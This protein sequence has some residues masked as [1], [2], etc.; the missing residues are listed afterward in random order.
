M[1]RSIPKPPIPRLP[2]ASDFLKNL[3]KFS[4]VATSDG[5]IPPAGMLKQQYKTFFHA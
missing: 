4:A 1:Y 5:Q 2:G 3:V